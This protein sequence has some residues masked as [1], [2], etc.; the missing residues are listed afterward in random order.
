VP[1]FFL[2][3]GTPPT[4]LYTGVYGAGSATFSTL[5][6]AYPQTCNA[7]GTAVGSVKQSFN[8]IPAGSVCTVT[9]TAD[10][11]ASSVSVVVEGSGRQ[12]TVPAAGTASTGITD[13]Y[14]RRP[15][16]PAPVSP[17]VPPV[18]VTG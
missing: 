14:S 5:G 17:I 7:P 9:E 8:G 4:Q 10:G 15:A 12:A 1:T 11:S 6:P 16:P 13:T 18:A 2:S 3:Q